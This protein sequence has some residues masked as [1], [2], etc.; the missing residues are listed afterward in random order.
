MTKQL[1]Y[2]TSHNPFS[3][4]YGANQRANVLLKAFI[5]NGY[6]IDVIFWGLKESKPTDIPQNVRII[7][8]E[9]D[10]ND[11]KPNFYSKYIS[12][13][14]NG[15]YYMKDNIKAKL[16]EDYINKKEYDIILTRYIQFAATIGVD[17]FINKLYLDVDDLPSMLHYT[18]YKN[19][20]SFI[21]KIKYYIIRF[22]IKKEETYW[23]NN[24]KQCFIPSKI[25]AKNLNITYLPNIP[26]F[27]SQVP[28]YL[29]TNEIFLFVGLLNYKPNYEGME[30]FIS[31][32]WGKIKIKHPNAL[33]KIAGKGL[34]EKL[35]E[36]WLKYDG[37]QILGFVDNIEEFYRSG[38]Y[39]ICPIYSGAGTNIKVL[40]AMA[41][42]KVCMMSKF[43]SRGF[44]TLIHHGINALVADSDLEYIS[45]IE[46]AL[47]NKS[48]SYTIANNAL[49]DVN[50]HYSQERINSIIKE[51]LI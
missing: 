37:I 47:S 2:I 33:L 51:K 5:A 23:I 17:K 30:H 22:L 45:N 3:S 13:F 50:K 26:F 29:G 21:E 34:P 12:R 7:Y 6:N 48:N 20:S 16:V 1:L 25:Q 36:N 27:H 19:K 41:M 42:G 9:L 49:N 11:S 38:D 43:A 31:N 10:K 35:K 44:E 14:I 39:V 28:Q 46:Y 40:E 32:I 18:D 8:W 15:R 24:A 4:S